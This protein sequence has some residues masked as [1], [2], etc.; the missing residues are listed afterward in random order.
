MPDDIAT[1]LRFPKTLFSMIIP[2]VD[3]TLK[4]MPQVKQVMLLGIETHVCVLQTTLELIER[5][6]EVHLL[7][8]GLR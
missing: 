3:T 1:A 8:D 4:Q 2:E 7:V 6:Y 5:G